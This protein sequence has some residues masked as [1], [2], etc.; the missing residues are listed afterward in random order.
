MINESFDLFIVC[1]I[2][3]FLAKKTKN[4][5]GGLEEALF[6]CSPGVGRE[7]QPS[8]AIVVHLNQVLHSIVLD[9]KM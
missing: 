2:H 9:S 5:L 4:R 1:L 3:Q 7:E 6:E 8:N